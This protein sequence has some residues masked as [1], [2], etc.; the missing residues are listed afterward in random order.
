V[1]QT[2]DF[3]LI[4][5]AFVRQGIM[6]SP[7]ELH[8]MLT[9]ALSQNVDLDPNTWVQQVADYLDLSAQSLDDLLV[10]LELLYRV[11]HDN[12]LDPELSFQPLLP[13]DNSELTVRVAALGEWSAGFLAGFG[14]Q[15]DS[16]DAVSSSADAT[17]KLSDD[18]RE[19]LQDLAA[20]S[21]V[22]VGGDEEQADDDI[23]EDYYMEIVEHAR[24]IALSIFLDCS[25][26][27][28]NEQ[29]IP[30][31]PDSELLH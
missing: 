24:V 1:E 22:G 31:A 17:A 21:Q 5:D 2:L 4:S 11:T 6:V 14:L 26:R 23:E 27:A 18:T 13:D 16:Q 8:G 3:D 15:E 29:G 9:G 7:A 10:E 30:D 25:A 28:S 12:L 20:I 19:A